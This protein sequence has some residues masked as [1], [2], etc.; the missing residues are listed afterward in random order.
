[1]A[2]NSE[3]IVIERTLD[4]LLHIYNGIE[5]RKNLCE[6]IC[7]DCQQ[8]I[9]PWPQKKATKIGNNLNIKN[10]SEENT[11]DLNI[12]INPLTSKEQE[13]LDVIERA[14]IKA[15]KTRQKF[16]AKIEDSDSLGYVKKHDKITSLETKEDSLI[17]NVISKSVTKEFDSAGAKQKSMIKEGKSDDVKRKSI[18]NLDFKGRNESLSNVKSRSDVRHLS[19][20]SDVAVIS[21]T[22]LESLR[23]IS[24]QNNSKLKNSHNPSPSVKYKPAHLTAPY[25]TITSDNSRQNK[26]RTQPRSSSSLKSGHSVSSLDHV[27]KSTTVILRKSELHPTLSSRNVQTALSPVTG[28]LLSPVETVTRLSPVETFRS[29]PETEKILTG[30]DDRKKPDRINNYSNDNEANINFSL[31]EDGCFLKLPLDFNKALSR[32]HQLREK[33]K[34]SQMKKLCEGESTSENFLCL[35]QNHIEE[36]SS[37][38]FAEI[39]MCHELGRIYTWL[40]SLLNQVKTLNLTDDT[41]SSIVFQAR[42]ILEFVFTEFDRLEDIYN[43]LPSAENYSSNN[44][45][46]KLKR[47]PKDVIQYWFPSEMDDDQYRSSQIISYQRESQ[48][49]KYTSLVHQMQI[50]K[51]QRFILKEAGNQTI[52][53]LQHLDPYDRLFPQIYRTAYSLI[54]SLGQSFPT[55][56][57][58]MVEE[59]GEE[60][61]E[62]KKKKERDGNELCLDENLEY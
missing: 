20:S 29:A 42:T 2:V 30:K 35:L 12:Q 8:L 62:K 18:G 25:K 59:K 4:R 34:N 33:L 56:V 39:K 3:I 61:E 57:K 28:G 7:L 32:N 46:G 1:M 26:L 51:L 47:Q 24:R 15:G 27:R 49:L 10:D 45:T 41:S 19:K 22:S 37:N 52:I 31:L 5:Y 44:I 16:Q 40:Q 58:D 60:I 53:L 50:L 55:V 11:K 36:R 38:E 13:E 48:L 43:S 17:E 23:S 54:C 14:L 21:E 6:K 9:R